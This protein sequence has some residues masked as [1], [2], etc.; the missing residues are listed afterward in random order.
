[1]GGVLDTLNNMVTAPITDLSLYTLAPT[2]PIGSFSLSPSNDSIYADSISTAV[3]TSDIIH[4]NNED[5]VDD[6][7]LFTI[8]TQAGTIIT[9]DVDSEREGIQVE[10]L[11]GVISFTIKSS[12]IA[13]NPK[14]SAF[15]VFGSAKADTNIVYYDTIPPVKPTGFAGI[16]KSEK[17][18]LTWN[19]N[20]EKDISG[21]IIYF[22][23]DTA[24]AP[25]E[26]IATVYGFPSPIIIGKDTSFTV[27]GLFND[28]TYY[29]AIKAYDISGNTSDYSIS[30]NATPSSMKYQNTQLTEG[31]NLI[32]FNVS[33]ENKQMDDMLQ[34]LID[35]AYLIKAIDENGNFVQEIPG[36]GW[37]NTIGEM[38]NE[39][40]YYVK[41]SADTDLASNGLRSNISTSIPLTQGWN[42]MGYPLENNQDAMNAYG[43]LINENKLVKVIN[44]SGGF[45]ENIPEVGWINTIGNLEPGEG[46]YIKLNTD[47]TLVL[48]E[49]GKKFYGSVKLPKPGEDY[50]NNNTG[51]PYL[52]M[53]IISTFKDS[54]QLMPGD[55][56]GV[57]VDDLCIGSTLIDEPGSYV[58]TYLNSNDPL[59][60]EKEG[61]DYGDE[62]IIKLIH[63]G[64]E[65]ELQE[66]NSG[67]EDLVYESLSTKVFK[68][69]AD[70]LGIDAT[71]KEEFYVSE[72]IPNPTKDDTRLYISSKVSGKMSMELV[73]IN[74][75][76]IRKM[77]PI[78]ILAGSQSIDID[79]QEIPSGLYFIRIEIQ[80]SEGIEQIN[81]KLMVGE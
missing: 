31:W 11:N 2:M 12:Y 32:S 74:G 19:Q 25:Y 13:G 9:A 10:A 54:L 64:V 52:P 3:I 36:T 79:I 75:R 23:S 44:E 63:K 1:M 15:S 65:Y 46:Y 14:I 16:A 42:I 53:H 61:G 78:N 80:H 77:D 40:G 73:D 66:L 30:I 41:V 71:S 39:E 18:T 81:K 60:E 6:G 26:G 62:L 72:P 37:L 8:N 55:E 35:S 57:F 4:Y 7:E 33:P 24:S 47:D 70:G 5:A 45:I 29:F 50:Q 17:V 56:L 38:K 20:Q 34:P 22:D 27:T 48:N 59:T 69:T 58:I 76:T 28:T 51:N 49:S 67:A 68:F 43:N 21:Y